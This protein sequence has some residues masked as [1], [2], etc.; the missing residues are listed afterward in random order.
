M[1]A[2]RRKGSAPLNLAARLEVPPER[3]VIETAV[4]IEDG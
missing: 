3:L 1:T 2:A 4:R